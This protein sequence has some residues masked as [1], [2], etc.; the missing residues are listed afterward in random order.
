MFKWLLLFLLLSTPAWAQNT[1]CATRPLGDMTNA[2]A[3]T[4]FVN[5]YGTGTTTGT[6]TPNLPVIGNAGGNGFAQGTRSG[7]TT[8]FSTVIG[9]LINGDCVSIDSNG[10]LIDAGGACTIGGGGGTVSSASKGQPAFYGASGTV[11]SG[12]GG[13]IY[14]AAT[15]VAQAITDCGSAANC[16]LTANLALTANGS[17]GAAKLIFP[18]GVEITQG[19]AYTLAIGGS[20]DAP[21]QQLFIGF[22]P[23]QISFGNNVPGQAAIH[24]EWWG[25]APTASAT[26]NTT[27]INNAVGACMNGPPLE[28]ATANVYTVAGVGTPGA[29][30]YN[31]AA[32]MINP[33]QTWTPIGASCV[34]K[35]NGATL[36]LANSNNFN[37]MAISNYTTC[38]DTYL[39]TI[40]DLYFDGNYANNSQQPA[41]D[42]YQNDFATTNI[43][44]LVLRN[45]QATGAMYD[46]F[47]FNSV[48]RSHIEVQSHNNAD[49]GVLITGQ[50]SCP[51]CGAWDY[52]DIRTMD[53]GIGGGPTTTGDCSQYGVYI[54]SLFYSR[55][56]IVSANNDQTDVNTC[57]NSPG[58][59]SG[60]A[61]P[62]GVNIA[63]SSHNEVYIVSDNDRRALMYDT[64]NNFN[65]IFLTATNWIAACTMSK[66][67][68]DPGNNIVVVRN[69]N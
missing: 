16:V 65:S 49:N 15:T 64:N 23:G 17:F 57:T 58:G 48:Q 14:T 30:G 26:L 27:A 4:A 61:Q 35:G 44:G 29:G 41:G 33:S 54:G 46:G 12:A 20:I 10:N 55:L 2:C 67:N 66:G 28:F 8:K 59:G 50:G 9:T 13:V 31:D 69:C 22:L 7:N 11:V 38:C 24:P 18:A 62:G 6:V 60:N 5:Q 53:N 68:P 63:N 45:V 43:S 40:E 21:I 19:A 56:N 34:I 1:T 39:I 52:F 37:I 47:A 36:K 3:S 51:Y 25:A 42:Q 32:I